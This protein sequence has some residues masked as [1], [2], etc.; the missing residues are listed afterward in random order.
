MYLISG[1]PI[2][3]I[4]SADNNLYLRVQL[5]YNIASM[6]TLTTALRPFALCILVDFVGT[7]CQGGTDHI[8]MHSGFMDYVR[9]HHSRARTMPQTFCPLPLLRYF[10]VRT[11]PPMSPIFKPR[12]DL[13]SRSMILTWTSL[14]V[15]PWD[16]NPPLIPSIDWLA[17]IQSRIALQ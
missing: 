17:A 8:L 15:V 1:W 10:F 13:V 5:E 16:L 12:W 3:L 4:M 6:V 2:L 11:W 14:Y 7:C 9:G